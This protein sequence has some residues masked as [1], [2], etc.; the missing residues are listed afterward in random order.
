APRP[1]VPPALPP[2]AA[3][4]PATAAPAPQATASAITSLAIIREVYDKLYNLN[5]PVG[6]V[7]DSVTPE[8]RTAI[9]SW[10]RRLNRPVTGDLSQADLL[11][12]RSAS[13]PTTWGA[14]A[15]SAGGATHAVWRQ[16]SRIV[17]ESSALNACRRAASNATCGVVTAAAKGCGA[18][19]HSIGTVGSTRHTGAFAAVRD[20]LVEASD[21]AMADCRLKGRVPS[22][23][24][25]RNVFCADGSHA[26]VG[27]G[28]GTPPPATQ[29][30]PTQTKPGL[31]L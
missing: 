7:S 19:A 16:P 10:Q 21:S 25:I 4:P 24:K 1:Q 17:A 12:L 23:C 14:L 9:S 29:P 15:Y 20:T 22:A 28:A 27:G 31:N 26:G 6:T 18:V 8:L 2:S 11:L 30:K 3:T 5:Y 13:I